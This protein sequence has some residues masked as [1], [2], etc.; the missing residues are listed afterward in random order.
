MAKDPHA[1]CVKKLLRMLKAADRHVLRVKKELRMVL[2]SEDLDPYPVKTVTCKF[3]VAGVDFESKLSAGQCEA[4]R[5][6]A[7]KG[8]NMMQVIEKLQELLSKVD[9]ASVEAAAALA[10]ALLAPPKETA[11]LGMCASGLGN[12]TYKV[13]G[14]EATAHCISEAQCD[15]LGGTWQP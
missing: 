1:K 6:V 7:V 14:D 3:A 4:I 9:G 11:P 8:G 13:D 12:C 2:R 5:E 10:K 15:V